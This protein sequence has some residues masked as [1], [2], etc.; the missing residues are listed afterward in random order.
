MPFKLGPHRL[1]KLSEAASTHAAQLKDHSIPAS[2]P[3]MTSIKKSPVTITY[4]QQ[5]FPSLP[6]R[7]RQS[8][9]STNPPATV[10]SNT[11]SSKDKPSSQEQTNGRIKELETQM[12][13]Q[14]DKLN[15][16]QTQ[17]QDQQQ[18]IQRLTNLIEEVQQITTKLTDAVQQLTNSVTQLEKTTTAL[19]KI[20]RKD[21]PS[22]T[23]DQPIKRGRLNQEDTNPAHLYRTLPDNNDI[24]DTNWDYDSPNMHNDDSKSPSPSL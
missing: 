20:Q 7:S 10:N 19:A 13:Q 21:P 9:S 24:N 4:D 11:S 2:F 1:T 3:N 12:S 23:I 15:N 16:I 22:P 17:L 14:Q 5:N 6:R 18:Q 8:D